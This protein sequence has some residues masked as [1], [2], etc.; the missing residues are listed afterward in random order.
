VPQARAQVTQPA[1]YGKF[2][3]KSNV[4][5]ASADFGDQ[6]NL[7]DG[8]LVFRA[9]DIE[10]PG[11]GPTIRLTRS[12]DPNGLGTYFHE[13]SGN[14]FGAWE[15]EIPRIA[16]ITANSPGASI[17]SPVGWQVTGTTTAEKDARCTGFSAPPRVSFP[18]DAARGWDAHEWWNGYHLVDD[19]G[20]AQSVMARA[21]T[22]IRPDRLLMTTGNWLIGCLSATSNGAPGEAF[23][24]VAPDGTKY[25]FDHLVYT[26][27]DTLQKPLWSGAGDPG[28]RAPH[29]GGK[30]TGTPTPQRMP[31]S[32]QLERRYAALLATRIEDRFGNWV[33]YHYTGDRLDSID[34]SDG[35]HVGIAYP[36]A[37]SATVTVGSGAGARTWSY[38]YAGSPNAEGDLQQLTVARPDGS[39]WQYALR[40]Q[41]PP[42][43]SVA[44]METSPTCPF[45]TVESNPYVDQTVTS[46]QGATLTMRVTSRRFGR[47]YV[48]KDCFNS[49][50]D[51]PDSGI[52]K[53]PR[54]WF[55]FAVTSRTVSGPGMATAT[56]NYS[57]APGVSSWLQDCPTPTSCA[58]TVWTDI[59]R[60]DGSRQRS[61]FS[62]KFDA[63]ENKLQREEEYTAGGALLRA[64]DYTYAT[65]LQADW[66]SN[67]YP[68]PV[69][70]GNDQQTRQNP[71][72]SGQWAPMRQRVVTQ[73]GKTFTW[74]VPF[75]CG[76]GSA[77]CFDPY[78]RPTRVVKQSGA[79]P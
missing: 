71:Q 1:E 37:S 29:A 75:V 69:S 42:S 14:A 41:V 3:G 2:V 13:S 65:V 25:W 21:D 74:Q 76:S 72:T 17:Y 77:P 59:T 63:T 8:K 47:S 22:T 46:P 4:V 58:S 11:T 12:F 39:T 70:V 35:R 16:T 53:Y 6:V 57:Y 43:M 40:W 45:D 32:D 66:T 52:M 54:E 30:Q 10:L 67:P 34:A 20:N 24:A 36:N 55:A 78:A 38:A 28:A 5:E 19:T 73:Q 15:I 27:A 79:A 56:W 62:N 49:R 44:E 68:W 7:R 60:P 48:P 23:L 50:P 64:T 33:T 31:E 61:I 26:D 18:S 9:T 51:I